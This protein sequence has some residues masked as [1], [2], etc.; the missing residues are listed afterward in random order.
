LLG[1]TIETV[2]RNLV[3]LEKQGI[4]RREGLHGIAIL[5][6]GALEALAG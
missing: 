1:L 5:D 2:S 4:I 3:A 6:R